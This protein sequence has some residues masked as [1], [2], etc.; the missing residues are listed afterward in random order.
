L[1]ENVKRH[2]IALSLALFVYSAVARSESGLEADAFIT[3]N[4]SNLV[5]RITNRGETPQTILTEHYSRG[6]LHFTGGK[7]LCFH[8]NFEI[9]AIGSVEPPE[10]WIFIPSLPK[11]AP[12]TLRKGETAK[13][14]VPLDNKTISEM[15]EVEGP[16]TIQ[17]S[18]GKKIAERFGLWQGTLEIRES[19]KSMK[20][21]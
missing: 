19:Y 7:L 10:Q 3:S 6:S 8:L 15:K 12:V 13:V 11:L 9:L 14:N 4:D 16:V 20:L 18:I 5:L 17:Y 1:E 2:S 21:K